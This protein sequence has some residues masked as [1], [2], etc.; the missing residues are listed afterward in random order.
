[1]VLSTADKNHDGMVSYAHIVVNVKKLGNHSIFSVGT[2]ELVNEEDT[3]A[4]NITVGLEGR[5]IYSIRKTL[6]KSCAGAHY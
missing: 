1:M 5:D 4:W 6:A 2:D 3:R